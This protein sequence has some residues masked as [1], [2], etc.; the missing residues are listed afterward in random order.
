MQFS[1]AKNIYRNKCNAIVDIPYVNKIIKN[2]LYCKI[3][4]NFYNV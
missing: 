1:Y 2:V 3:T 4:F